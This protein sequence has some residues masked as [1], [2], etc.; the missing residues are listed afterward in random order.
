[1]IEE[2]TKKTSIQDLKD[3]LNNNW[4]DGYTIPSATLYPFQWNWDAG[5]IALALTYMNQDRAMQEVNSMFDSQWS[6]GMLPH[7][8]FHK[9]NDNYFP[10][11]EVWQTDDLEVSSN[12]VSST[13]ITQPPVFGFILK[14]MHQQ[15]QGNPKWMPFLKALFPK[16][17]AF[18]RYLYTHR[19]PHQ[20]GL[21]YIQHNWESGTDN[22][23]LWD[24]IF[25]VSYTHL[26]AHERN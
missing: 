6:N 3:I 17:V 18:H 21:V 11:P 16:V 2:I 25:A 8:A 15:M 9:L 19:D 5:F 14:R 4:R 23:P 24:H 22:S 10:G 20:E 1:M 7:I 13:G 12:K 26:R